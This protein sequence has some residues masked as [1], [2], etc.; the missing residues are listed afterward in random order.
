MY[1]VSEVGLC[2]AMIKLELIEW[3]VTIAQISVRN[4]NPE[5]L[6]FYFLKIVKITFSNSIFFFHFDKVEKP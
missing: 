4:L 5:G 6:I 1:V 3:P 2:I